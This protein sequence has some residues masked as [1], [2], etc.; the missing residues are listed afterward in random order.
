M[1]LH[2]IR[3][4]CLEIIKTVGKGY[5]WLQDKVRVCGLGLRSRLNAEME[6]AWLAA[7]HKC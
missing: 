2:G 5:V 6:Y 3:G 7:L 4:W 1:Y